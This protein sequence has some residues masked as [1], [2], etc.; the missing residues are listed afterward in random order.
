MKFCLI[1]PPWYFNDS[2]EFISHN[3]G[4]GYITSF[5][6]A[7]GHRVQFIDA[8]FEGIDNKTPVNF[9]YQ[10]V[11]RYGASY[12][13]IVSKI[14]PD[15]DYIGI[16]GP[17]TDSA[18]ILDE[19]I[20]EIKNRYPDKPVIAGGIYPSTLP[21]RA[22]ES[23]ADIVIR[24]E[25]E[26]ALLRL[27]EGDDPV[28][29]NGAVFYRYGKLVDNGKAD[30]IADLD[31][32]PFPSYTRRPVDSYF[33]WSPRGDRKNRTASIITS[34]GCPY[35]CNFCSIHPVYGRKWRARSPE[36]VLQEI[37]LL[38]EEHGIN[39]LEFEDDNLTLRP[40]RAEAILD[41]ISKINRGRR[42]RDMVTWSAPNGVRIDTLTED[43]M[44]KIKESSCK[45][46]CLAVESGDPDMLKLMNKKLDLGKVEKTVRLLAEHQINTNAFFIIGYPGETEKRFLNSL[47]FAK[48]LQ[49]LGLNSISVLVA[50]P[51]PGT[52]LFS[53][54]K[55]KGYLRHPDTGNVLHF[56]QYSS[57]NS[58]FIQIETP[59]FSADDLMRRYRHFQEAFGLD[60]V[61]YNVY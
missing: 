31:T 42:R 48:K 50:T 19:L 24:G 54:C 51:Y 37:E 56:A 26:L 61:K 12:E 29:I 22:L 49:K 35:S 3:L 4:L 16:N 11:Y 5:L 36:N 33:G 44:L 60:E 55:E 40:E 38:V 59:D 9:P 7:K 30:L 41:G 14:A 23:G 20:K 45:A 46:L 17:F 47:A 2:I 15:A 25:G 28:N 39:H 1:N 34:R 6:E 32:I 13:E 58:D 43:L 21:H 8:L 27:A 52:V 57:Y 10:N 18:T 53:E